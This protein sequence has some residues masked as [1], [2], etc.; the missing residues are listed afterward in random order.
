MVG[1]ILAVAAV[2]RRGSLAA[3]EEEEEEGRRRCAPEAG[4][5]HSIELFL[6][7]FLTSH[8]RKCKS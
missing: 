1:R 6:Y 5:Q 3:E 4:C 8:A 2:A 7:F